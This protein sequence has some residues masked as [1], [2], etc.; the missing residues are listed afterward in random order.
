ME[1]QMGEVQVLAGEL[2]CCYLK[3]MVSFF[4]SI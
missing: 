1:R 2:K 4:C 3:D